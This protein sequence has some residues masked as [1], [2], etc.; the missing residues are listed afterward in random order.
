M[1]ETWSYHNFSSFQ[2]FSSIVK[3]K[4]LY[5]DNFPCFLYNNNFIYPI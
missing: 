3:E 4:K 2:F 1:S 5:I